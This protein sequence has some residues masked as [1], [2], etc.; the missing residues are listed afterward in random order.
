MPD[1]AAE[2]PNN[3]L[4]QRVD[5]TFMEAGDRAGVASVAIAR[6]AAVVDLNLDGLLDLV[7]VN[8]WKPAQVWRN[9][10]TDAGNWIEVLLDQPG[11]PNRAAVGAWLEVRR[12]ETV[13][14][15][16]ITVG[17]GHASGE[18]GWWHVGLGSDDDAEMRVVWPDGVADP[19]QP[20]EANRFYVARR[21]APPRPWAVGEVLQ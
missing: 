6:G 15:R 5:G 3:L 10:S 20:V 12:G 18:A 16:E 2:D 19:W 21:G 7:V 1:F 4:L 13:T 17:G 14:R 8:R 11:S 9:A